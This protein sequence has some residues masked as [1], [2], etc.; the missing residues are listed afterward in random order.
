[1]F[2]NRHI[3]CRRI[4]KIILSI[5]CLAVLAEQSTC[6]FYQ[7]SSRH[8]SVSL[9]RGTIA[10]NNINRNDFCAHPGNCRVG[11]LDKRFDFPHFFYLQDISHTVT[12]VTRHKQIFAALLSAN[13]LSGKNQTACMRGPPAMHFSA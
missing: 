3:I 7:L 12:G 1:M 8:V 11:S 6:R 5:I 4:S 2:R 9:H 13:I 10:A